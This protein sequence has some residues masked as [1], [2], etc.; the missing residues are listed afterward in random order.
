MASEASEDVPPRISSALIVSETV[1]AS[2]RSTSIA[3]W[4]ATEDATVA[5][6]STTVVSPL[7]DITVLAS[8]ISPA[9][10]SK[11]STLTA[12]WFADL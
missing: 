2:F 3:S 7:E 9:S 5:T 8:A 11:P 6:T 12:W 1:A 4:V 10:T